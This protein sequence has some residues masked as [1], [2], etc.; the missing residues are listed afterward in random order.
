MF[1]KLCYIWVE[2]YR[3]FQE[4]GFNFS[5]DVKFSYDNSNKTLKTVNIE[6]LPENFFGQR[7]TDVTGLIGKNGSGKSNVLELICKLLKGGK[8]ALTKPFLIVTYETSGYVCLKSNLTVSDS[9][10]IPV[11]E[12]DGNIDPLKIIYFSNVFDERVHNF[13][14]AVSDIS[15]NYRYPRN[16][17]PYSLNRTTSD[18]E[19]QIKFI[20]SPAFNTLNIEHPKKIRLT[21]NYFNKRK[22]FRKVSPYGNDEYISNQIDQFLSSFQKRTSDLKSSNKFFFYV[23]VYTFFVETLRFLNISKSK[24]EDKDSV[25][26]KLNE[27]FENL[28]FSENN[29]KRTDIIV[30]SLIEWMIYTL[31]KELSYIKGKRLENELVELLKNIRILKSLEE[32]IISINIEVITEGTRSRKSTSFV[33]DSIRLKKGDNKSFFELF[34]NSRMFSIDWVGISSGHKAY[35][36]IF[37][38]L[39]F[40][41]KK[42]RKENTLIC[43]DE[44]DLYLHPKWQI[45]FF[46]K[47][48]NN[49]PEIYKGNIQLILTSHS[50]F[51]LSDLP[52]Q[53]VTIIEN[54]TPESS[55]INGTDLNKQTFAGNIY[56][57]YAEPFFLNDER[58]SIF[59]KKKIKNLASRLNKEKEDL[60]NTEIYDM[61][62]EI[63]FIGDDI[64]R[65]HLWNRLETIKK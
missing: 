52:K 16:R 27:L 44:G 53:N 42:V 10:G 22:Y 9:S 4:M 25:L 7:I 3:N 34:Q 18:F 57:L 40:E 26:Y 56:N 8:A 51:L 41:L 28:G 13:D 33:I 65:N 39:N 59:A 63:K 20:D 21:S 48:V 46:D 15:N 36:N 60:T 2:D 55:T 64:I 58:T 5:S 62:R 17:Y 61:E 6:P 45:E 30:N 19:K 24:E 37:S 11:E 23:V 50:P 35:L 14:R 29:L 1:L 12:Y 49:L 47:L 54:E 43:I 38:L 31:D 32:Y